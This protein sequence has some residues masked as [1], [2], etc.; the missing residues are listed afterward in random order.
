[1]SIRGGNKD[2][3]G[4]AGFISKPRF[5]TRSVQ[6]QPRNTGQSSNSEK[7]PNPRVPYTTKFE[8]SGSG[9]G[10]PGSGSGGFDNN[11]PDPNWVTNPDK[12]YQIQENP[13]VWVPNQGTDAN[14]CSVDESEESEENLDSSVPGC[15]PTNELTKQKLE[16][17]PIEPLIGYLN[18]SASQD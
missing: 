2:S 10:D 3:S 6:D 15:S 12:W 8:N 5:D 13:N 18:S 14:S 1:V 17:Y 7:F 9:S 4:E 16:N 11:G